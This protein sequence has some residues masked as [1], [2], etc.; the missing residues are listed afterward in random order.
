MALSYTESNKLMQDPDFR[1]RV[2]VACLMYAQAINIE[3][4]DTV[5]HNTRFKWAGICADNP[6]FMTNKVTPN[7]TMDPAVQSAGSA[8]DD[9]ALQAA[10]QK[11]VDG[12]M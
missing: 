1:G 3:P 5:G 9:A 4:T 2:K 11:T 8:I 10:V 7:A 12:I 6:E